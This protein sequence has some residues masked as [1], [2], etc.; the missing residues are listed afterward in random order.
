MDFLGQ[1]GSEWKSGCDSF[2][3]GHSGISKGRG[4]RLMQDTERLKCR[5]DIY[6]FGGMIKAGKWVEDQNGGSGVL[7][8]ELAAADGL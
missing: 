4:K 7:E 8:R 2:P 1:A 3:G 5:K 6:M